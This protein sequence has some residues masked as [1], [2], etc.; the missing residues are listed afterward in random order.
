M[1]EILLGVCAT[2]VI[3]GITI[4]TMLLPILAI[5]LIWSEFQR[6]KENK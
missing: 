4:T 1:V 2:I 6:G 5:S 3:A